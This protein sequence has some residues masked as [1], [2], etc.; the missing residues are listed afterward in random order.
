VEIAQSLLDLGAR[1]EDSP[2]H[3]EQLVEADISRLERPV[4]HLQ[5]PIEA[6]RH[7][8]EVVPELSVE[9]VE[10]GPGRLQLGSGGSQHRLVM[11]PPLLA[12]RE[13]RGDPSLVSIEKWQRE[14]GVQA[15]KIFAPVALIA[16]ADLEGRHLFAAGDLELFL[17]AHVRLLGR[18]EVGA[19]LPKI[20]RGFLPRHLHGRVG[21]RRS[22]LL[23]ACSVVGGEANGAIQRLERPLALSSEPQRLAL[24]VLRGRLREERVERRRSTGVLSLPGAGQ[25]AVAHFALAL[26]DGEGVVGGEQLDEREA[27]L[28]GQPPLFLGDL[29][30]HL[31]DVD[32][33]AVL[34]KPAPE[35][36]CVRSMAASTSPFHTLALVGTSHLVEISGFGRMPAA[37]SCASAMPRC[38][39]KARRSGL[40]TTA[41]PAASS[42]ERPFE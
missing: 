7:A 12:L 14:R 28:R 15:E 1:L 33:G 26:H 16:R 19:P 34:F 20:E 31:F 39:R 2:L 21:Q 3:A 25:D 8:V 40:S 32:S 18:E 24:D 6:W 5:D 17:G 35:Q 9:S 42:A 29:P 30:A 11:P 38:K 41:R 36:S 10:V 23:D 37:V 13:L 27:H 4:G 22:G